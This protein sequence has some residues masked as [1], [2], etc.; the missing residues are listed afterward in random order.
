MDW[1]WSKLESGASCQPIELNCQG[2]SNPSQTLAQPGAAGD[3]KQQSGGNSSNFVSLIVLLP[4]GGLR[5][6]SAAG[7]LGGLKF[8]APKW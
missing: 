1:N 4:G 6:Q 3:G 8:N 7:M 2:A 5:S